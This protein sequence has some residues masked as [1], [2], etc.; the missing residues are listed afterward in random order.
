MPTK[1][2]L[3]VD[4]GTDDA[5]A[6]MAAA[7]HPDLDLV[8]VTTVNGNVPVEVATENTL[9]V[10]DHIGA[11]IPVYEG[12]ARPMVR[13]DFPV[14][15]SEGGLLRTMHG[16]YL[17]LPQAR[18]GKQGQSAVRFLVDYYM[19]PHGPDT[20]LVPTGPLTNIALAFATAPQ[21]VP[22]IP[23]IV[24]MGGGHE[25]GNVTP[26]A[27]FNVW[28]DPEAARVVVRSGA[29]DLLVVPL[30]C[31]H[32]TV[33]S[34]ADCERLAALA[35][36]AGLA[37]SALIRHRIAAHDEAQPLEV[38]HTAAVHDAVCV[39]SLARPD[40][41]RQTGRYNVDVETSGEL[42][43]GRTVIDTHRRSARAPNATVAL[44]GDR[45][46]LVD[47]LIDT[48]AITHPNTRG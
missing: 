23:R 5:V 18:A 32:Q 10:L 31:T 27:E 13:P 12:A 26:S 35:T 8:A 7:L 19:G 45:E 14:P 17:D 44:G 40:V 28:A 4:T 20:V 30:D 3:D 39:A 11:D 36:P 38:E 25:I 1:V 21:I 6:V 43:V 24:S 42:C 41:L 2:I 33:V 16:L 46:V 48:F 47:F 34:A 29:R 37:A 9:R 15:R 22:R